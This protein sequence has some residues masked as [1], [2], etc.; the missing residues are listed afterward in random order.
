MIRVLIVEDDP[1]VAEINTQYIQNV[2]GFE[3]V[4]W[5][6]DGEQ[7]LDLMGNMSIDLLILDVFMPRMDG[8]ELLKQLRKSYSEVDI[9]FV[10]AAKERNIIDQGLKL[11]AVDYLIKPFKFD[12]IRISLEKYRKRYELFN[13][14]EE[15]NQANL[16]CLF[17]LKSEAEVPKGIHCHTL[18]LIKEYITKAEYEIEVR[19]LAEDLAISTV[20]IRHYLDYLTEINVLTKDLKYGSVGRPIYIYHQCVI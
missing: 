2:K 6:E 1:M 18:A 9:I 11:G 4:G 19:K 5:S 7:A 14:H 12:R 20:T 10:T 17:E 8:L 13:D 3:V 15:I 16:D